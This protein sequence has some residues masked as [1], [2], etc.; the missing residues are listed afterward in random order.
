MTLY[1]QLIAAL[2]P[3]LF[4]YWAI[5]AFSAKRSID[6]HKWCTE[7]GMRLVL[8]VIDGASPADKLLSPLR[9][10]KLIHL[11]FMLILPSVN[12]RRTR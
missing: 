11:S 7:R 1:G 3:V 4:L 6:T 10:P 8:L 9:N 2:W 5:A 12:S